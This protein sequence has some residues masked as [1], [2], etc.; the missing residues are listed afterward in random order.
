MCEFR[1]S[2]PLQDFLA[3]MGDWQTCGEIAACRPDDERAS[4]RS[5]RASAHLVPAEVYQYSC[6]M[7]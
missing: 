3:T 1:A 4:A 7:Q 5:V 2:A 6:I